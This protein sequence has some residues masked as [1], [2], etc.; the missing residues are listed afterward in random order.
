MEEPISE[1]QELGALTE[2]IQNRQIREFTVDEMQPV[3]ENTSK[4][5]S[6]EAPSRDW[7]FRYL[8]GHLGNI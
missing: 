4:D 5:D 7:L 3:V 6:E 2:P 8:Y 1:L